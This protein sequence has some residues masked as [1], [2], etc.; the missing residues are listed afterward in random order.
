MDDDDDEEDLSLGYLENWGI[1]WPWLLGC[2]VYREIGSFVG[3][4][5]GGWQEQEEEEDDEVKERNEEKAYHLNGTRAR[6]L[7][8]RSPGSR[9]TLDYMA[10]RGEEEGDQGAGDI[11][12]EW[13]GSVVNSGWMDGWRFLWFIT[14]NVP[15]L[16]H[17]SSSLSSA[18]SLSQS[19][20]SF[21][22]SPIY[23]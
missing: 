8:G 3:L 11:I 19:S 23:D 4:V 1:G 22:K 6:L 13:A 5:G 14:F 17:T 20:K 18:S 9:F 15:P 12:L 21:M 2:G 10:W 16:F 7:S